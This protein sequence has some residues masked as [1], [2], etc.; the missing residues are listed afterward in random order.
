MTALEEK[1]LREAGVY[2]GSFKHLAK[3]GQDVLAVNRVSTVFE[4]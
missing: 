3:E 2:F 1:F 4:I